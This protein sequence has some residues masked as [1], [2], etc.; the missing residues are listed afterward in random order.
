MKATE[1][2]IAQ[3]QI[4]QQNMNNILLQKQQFQRQL[5]EVDSAL[6][7]LQKTEKAYR[8]IGNIMVAG[9][10]EDVQKHLDEKKEMHE[11]RV[12]NLERQEEAIKKKMEEIQSDVLEEMKR[13]QK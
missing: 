5:V 10:K 9:K 12:K 3:L 11:L 1:Q 4:M 8:I 6:A 13:Q 2:K 7:E